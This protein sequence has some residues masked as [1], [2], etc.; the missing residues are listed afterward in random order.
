MFLPLIPR[1]CALSRSETTQDSEN[2][3]PGLSFSSAA[4]HGETNGLYAP[5]NRAVNEIKTPQLP[6]GENAAVATGAQ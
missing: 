4:L 6:L 1:G 5:I 2:G 3:I